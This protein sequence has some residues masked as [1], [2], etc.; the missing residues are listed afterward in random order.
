MWGGILNVLSTLWV[1]AGA[2]FEPAPPLR[3]EPGSV[4]RVQNPSLSL[5]VGAGAWFEAA[6][7]RN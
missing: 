1:S 4:D 3:Q 2:G 5:L 7:A 6:R